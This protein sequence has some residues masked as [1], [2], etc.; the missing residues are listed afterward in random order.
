MLKPTVN[1]PFRTALRTFATYFKHIDPKKIDPKVKDPTLYQ[2]PMSNPDG[3][4]K[5]YQGIETFSHNA[6]Q[7]LILGPHG[8]LD[9]EAVIKSN[10]FPHTG[11]EIVLVDVNT[12]QQQQSL[13]LTVNFVQSCQLPCE[14]YLLNQKPSGGFYAFNNIP[15]ISRSRIVATNV[16]HL[17]DSEARQALFSH[18]GAI[19]AASTGIES[20]HGMTLCR[21]FDNVAK[22]LCEILSQ[23][24][25]KTWLLDVDELI[26]DDH[27]AYRKAIP[28]AIP[29]HQIEKEANASLSHIRQ[30]HDT[31]TFTHR[32]QRAFFNS[33]ASIFHRLLD[34]LAMI[35]TDINT[36]EEIH[37]RKILLKS[38][39]S[40]A[41]EA[42]QEPKM[43]ITRFLK[44]E[45]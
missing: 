35:E 28:K 17:M 40:A 16:I 29:K 24:C 2:T 1:K 44:G 32:D 38:S 6:H 11:A 26:N 3:F 5:T 10:T 12:R 42:S 31:F 41:V 36:Y 34:P 14:G 45:D 30:T 13:P 22:N 43:V 4:G 25:L 37:Y 20:S 15:G 21:A 9:V 27:S 23:T 19:L 33:Y 8:R 39:I 7:V 18:E